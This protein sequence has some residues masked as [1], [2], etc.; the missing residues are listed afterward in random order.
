MR[1]HGLLTL[2][3]SVREAFELMHYLDCACR[4]VGAMAGGADVVLLMQ[5]ARTAAQ[6]FNRRERLSERRDWPALLR[7]LERRGINDRDSPRGGGPAGRA[8]DRS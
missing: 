1:N 5:A 4:M 3:R 7:M 8:R 6:Q 2:G